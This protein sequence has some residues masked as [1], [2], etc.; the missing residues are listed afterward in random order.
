[1]L[2]MMIRGGVFNQSI[3]VYFHRFN[4]LFRVH[5]FHSITIK[6]VARPQKAFTST[7]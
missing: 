5:L 4:G 3:S 7:Q 6:V 1:M 2:V